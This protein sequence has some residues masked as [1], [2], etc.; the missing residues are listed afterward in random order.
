MNVDDVT[1]IGPPSTS[2]YSSLLAAVAFHSTFTVVP[3]PQCLGCSQ[4]DGMDQHPSCTFHH[5][6]SDRDETNAVEGSSASIYLPV[7]TVFLHDSL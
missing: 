1:I 2:E 4:G 5:N 3:F 7:F 6:N